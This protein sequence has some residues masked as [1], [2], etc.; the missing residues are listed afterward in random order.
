M[1]SHNTEQKVTHR[2][3]ASLLLLMPIVSSPFSVHG[4][5]PEGRLWSLSVV[6]SFT[7]NAIII[8]I[9]IFIKV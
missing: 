1:A 4:A 6:L 3:R 9:I 5:E 2:Q 7:S 8:I